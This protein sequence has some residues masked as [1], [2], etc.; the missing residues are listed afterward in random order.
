MT[1]LRLFVSVTQPFGGEGINHS[2]IQYRINVSA[3]AFILFSFILFKYLFKQ[4]KINEQYKEALCFLI[5]LILGIFFIIF[6]N[7]EPIRD[8]KA[9]LNAADLLINNGITSVFESSYFSKSPYQIGFV[10]YL[11]LFKIIFHNNAIIAIQVFQ[12]I[13]FS[14]SNIFLYR[15][16][17]MLT[18]KDCFSIF[19]YLSI[20][21]IIPILYNLYIYG[22]SIGLSLSIIS[23]Y[24]LFKFIDLSNRKYFIFSLLLAFMAVFLK[25]NFLI[26]LVSYLLYFIF[27][28]PKNIKAKLFSTLFIIVTI[29]LANNSY[30]FITKAF[31]NYD[32]PKGLPKTSWLAM[33]TIDNPHKNSSIYALYTPGFYN[34]YI[35]ERTDFSSADYQNYLQEDKIHLQNSIK[36]AIN[37]P[38]HAVQYYYHKLAF[39]WAFNDFFVISELFNY[40]NPPSK[41][42]E[43]LKSGPGEFLIDFFIG[44]IVLIIYIGIFYFIGGNNLNNKSYLLMI[45]VIGGF[46]FHF[47]FE[48]R[49]TYIYPYITILIPLASVGLTLTHDYI[50]DFIFHWKLPI[51]LIL[52]GAIFINNK[53]NIYEQFEKESYYV[54][55]TGKQEIDENIFVEFQFNT[56]DLTI[57]IDSFEIYAQGDLIN[58]PLIAHIES[59]NLDIYVHNNPIINNDDNHYRFNLKDYEVPL[60]ETFKVTLFLDKENTD[61]ASSSIKIPYGFNETNSVRINDTNLSN[62]TIN[63]KLI[64]KLHSKGIIPNSKA[65]KSIPLIWYNTSLTLK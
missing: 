23:I 59:S 42:I 45:Y 47:L 10:F 29:L 54:Y 57:P 3:L 44:G 32:T 22:F 33:A 9:C 34:G 55:E 65:K 15:I 8:A 40:D 60:N 14:L 4:S 39:T 27:L 41:T 5:P 64:T 52:V 26:L 61:N 37:N 17:C 51:I 62:T 30:H 18:K 38:Y 12:L 49:P 53:I 50:N 46:L 63:F 36:M 11:A 1:L 25:P 2:F 16:T 35:D 28:Y 19:T 21:W 31:F 43:F 7:D 13:L 48:T 24:F 20:I 56:N 6:I 58:N